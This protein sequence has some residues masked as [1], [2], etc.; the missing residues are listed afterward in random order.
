MACGCKKKKASGVY[1][2]GATWKG[3]GTAKRGSGVRRRR[4]KKGRGVSMGG[5]G[6]SFRGSGIVFTGNGVSMKASRHR[7][8]G[9]KVVI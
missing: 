2:K 6:V 3:Y 9:R 7:R 5:S 1:L 8:V 4:R